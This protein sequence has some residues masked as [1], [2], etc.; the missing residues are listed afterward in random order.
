MTAADAI[1]T[2]FE[3][4]YAYRHLTPN[5]RLKR[6]SLVNKLAPGDTEEERLAWGRQLFATLPPAEQALVMLMRVLV[7]DASI[8]ILDEVFAGMDDTMINRTRDYLQNEVA[9]DKA[10]IFVT[11]WEHEV[12]WSHSQM[13]VIEDGIGKAQ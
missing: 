10:V 1:G 12:P 6:D 9:T 11:H 3:G 13:F 2:G 7:S 4:T 8:L 5:Q